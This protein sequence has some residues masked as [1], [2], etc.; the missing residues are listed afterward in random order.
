MKTSK[1]LAL[2][3][4]LVMSSHFIYAQDNETQS[5][6]E[7]SINDQFEFILRKSGNFK[8]TN[9]QAYEAVNRMMLLTLQAHTIDSLKT[10]QSKLDSA[11]NTIQTQ[12]KEIENLKTNLS[13]TQTKLDTTNK[14]KNNMSLLGLQ[15]SKTSYNILM[16]TI[17]GGLLTLLLIF[18]FKFKNSNAVTKAAKKALIETE[19][20]FEEHRRLALEREQKVRRQLQDE[21]NKQKGIS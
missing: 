14:E 17:I 3:L 6:N 21:L 18:I 9:G 1:F 15:M 5:L 4:I 7:G 8:G 10:L 13:T 2:T 19:E 16:W 20:E 12:Q 11:N